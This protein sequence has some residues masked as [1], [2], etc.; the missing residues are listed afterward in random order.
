MPGYGPDERALFEDDAT[1]LY[2]EICQKGG[3]S[4]S[5]YRIAEDG[6]L[7]RAFDLLVEMG[8]LIFDSEQDAIRLANATEYGLAAGIWTR[9]V[10]R[11]MRV[12]RELDAGTVWT[13][14]WAAVVDQFEEGGFKQ[15]GVVRL[16]GLRSLEEFL[17]TKTLLHVVPA[18]E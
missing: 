2:E 15:S 7:R 9:D 16:N 1:K 10:D 17:E 5:D 3:I 8:L 14:T 18:G 6:E 12:G 11:P 13:N 4:A